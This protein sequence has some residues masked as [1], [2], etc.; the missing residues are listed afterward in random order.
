MGCSL[1]ED[2]AYEGLNL[3]SLDDVLEGQMGLEPMT[4]CLKGRCSNQLSYWPATYALYNNRGVVVNIGYL[5]LLFFS[6]TWAG[7]VKNK[8]TTA[9]ITPT[10]MTISR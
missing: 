7:L 9:R 2:Q 1:F 8:S 10:L 4:P 6:A 5:F 3:G